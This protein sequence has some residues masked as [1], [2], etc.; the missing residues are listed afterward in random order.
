MQRKQLQATYTDYRDFL[1][2]LDMVAEINAFIPIY[3]ERINQLINKTNQF[4]LTTKRYNISEIREASTDQNNITMYGKLTDKFGENGLISVIIGSIKKNEL[5]INIWVMSCRVF[6]RQVE[7]EIFRKITKD[8]LEAGIKKIK[9]QYS[10]QKKNK[11]LLK[12]VEDIGFIKTNKNGD[13][14]E[15]EIDI[16]NYK[17]KISVFN[18]D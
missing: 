10:P 11:L 8:A 1:K 5:H 2:S 3:L 7:D 14:L 13:L 4:N 12:I 6:G 18:I 17:N 15:F 16:C 9:L